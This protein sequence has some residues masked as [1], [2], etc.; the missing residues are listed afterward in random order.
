MN[1]HTT[2]NRRNG[3]GNREHQATIRPFP[4][5]TKGHCRYVFVVVDPTAVVVPFKEGSKLLWQNLAI[6]FCPPP[7]RVMDTDSRM[8]RSRDRPCLALPYPSSSVLCCQLCQRAIIY[9][10]F[11]T[12]SGS[13]HI[14]VLAS[15][16]SLGSPRTLNIR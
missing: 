5:I 11:P 10:H 9:V 2:L 7:S 8:F 6:T 3:Y 13:V 15:L 4:N 16:S 14:L 1:V 12:I